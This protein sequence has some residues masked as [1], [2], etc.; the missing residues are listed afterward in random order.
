MFS[1]RALD[2]RFRIDHQQAMPERLRPF[3]GKYLGGAL[4]LFD[5]V[6]PLGDFPAKGKDLHESDDEE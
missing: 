6:S 2:I 3:G 5:A 4:P 1:L